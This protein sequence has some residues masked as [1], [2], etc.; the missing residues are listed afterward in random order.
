M[1]ESK[2]PSG[3][4]DESLVVNVNVWRGSKLSRED[5][6]RRVRSVQAIRVYEN[7]WSSQE[8]SVLPVFSCLPRSLESWGLLARLHQLV[9]DG[10]F[11]V[12]EERTPDRIFAITLARE[13]VRWL[14]GTKVRTIQL[15]VMN[16]LAA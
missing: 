12:F 8:A 4:P 14:L 9:N 13:F 2:E 1:S 7:T 10:D 15:Q 5:F 11:S 6:L 3:T 16:W